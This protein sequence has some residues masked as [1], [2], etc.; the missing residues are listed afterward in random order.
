[1]LFQKVGTFHFHLPHRFD[2][3]W[4]LRKDRV[5]QEAMNQFSMITKLR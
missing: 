1:M 4:D 2:R 5:I 3:G